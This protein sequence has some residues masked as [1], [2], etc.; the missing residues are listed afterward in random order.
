M[1]TPYPSKL[2]DNVY[3]LIAI[4]TINACLKSRYEIM[5][6]C[7]S[8]SK[9]QVQVFQ[10]TLHFTVTTFHVN[11]PMIFQYT[12]VKMQVNTPDVCGPNYDVPSCGTSLQC[13]NSGHCYNGRCCLA[14]CGLGMCTPYPYIPP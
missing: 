7:M 3:I 2:L 4:D 9:P 11:V 14:D 5:P 8:D 6:A 10:R 1:C 12:A 13:A